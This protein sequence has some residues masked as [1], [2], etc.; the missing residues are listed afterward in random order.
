MY[1]TLP[2]PG[3]L[4]SHPSLQSIL[5][6]FTSK[7][8]PSNSFEA[9][10]FQTDLVPNTF[11]FTD[12][13]TLAV[14]DPS[15]TTIPTPMTT[16]VPHSKKKQTRP[17]TPNLT[18]GPGQLELEKTK[19]LIQTTLT[20]LPPF[21]EDHWK[22]PSQHQ[23]YLLGHQGQTLMSMIQ[24]HHTST[25]VPLNI[26]LLNAKYV[27]HQLSIRPAKPKP[28]F[29]HE[30]KNMKQPQEDMEVVVLRGLQPEV[31]SI[32]QAMQL[33]LDQVH[34]S[35]HMEKIHQQVF[36]P[37]SFIGAIMGPAR[38]HLNKYKETIGMVRVEVQPTSSSSSSSSSTALSSTST[39]GMNFKFFGTSTAV[40]QVVQEVTKKLKQLQDFTVTSIKIPPFYHRAIL[41]DQGHRVKALEAQ[42]HVKIQFPSYQHPQQH[43]SSSANG[44][45]SG[46]RTAAHASSSLDVDTVVVKGP[47]QGVQQA[48]KVL[49]QYHDHEVLH[50][51]TDTFKV[52]SRWIPWL[53]G[54]QGTKLTL[55]RDQLHTRIDVPQRRRK[56]L[57]V[58]D[59]TSKTSVHEVTPPQV[60]HEEED[61]EKEKKGK[62]DKK[63][64]VSQKDK[65]K[66]D[67]ENQKEKDEDSDGVA[68]SIKGT[69][70]QVR[71]TQQVFAE[72]VSAMQRVGFTWVSEIIKVPEQ[73]HRR[74]LGQQ[75][76]H[77]R[78]FLASFQTPSTSSSTSTTTTT[79][80]TEAVASSS[81]APAKNNA[82]SVKSSSSKKNTKKNT[83]PSTPSSSSTS[84]SSE[85]SVK[86]APQSATTK[87][88]SSG[89]TD[90]AAIVKSIYGLDIHPAPS[91][92]PSLPVEVKFLRHPKD[93]VELRATTLELL[94]ELKKKLLSQIQQYQLETI[95]V[96]N[97][98]V[99]YHS[100]L[101]GKNGSITKSIQQEFHVHLDFKPY[102]ITPA[103]HDPAIQVYDVGSRFQSMNA[104]NMTLGSI[105]VSGL[106][107][108]VHL[109]IQ[110]LLSRTPSTQTFQVPLQYKSQVMG[111]QGH[112]L[113]RLRTQFHVTVTLPGKHTGG[114]ST[115]TILTPFTHDDPSSWVASSTSLDPTFDPHLKPNKN[116]GLEGKEEMVEAVETWVLQGT[117]MD[118]TNGLNELQR[119]LDLAQS[120]KGSTSSSSSKKVASSLVK[121]H[122][123]TT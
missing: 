123:T 61:T 99:T 84:L 6:A 81:S 94:Q 30:P 117:E 21:L 28:S 19:H 89:N 111:H 37:H 102:L 113:R 65:K 104:M 118:V 82:P 72:T 36:V 92:E 69:K 96:L 55:L 88:S 114:A 91:S 57:N 106:K 83:T 67:V 51:F 5:T 95:M 68:I 80:T 64:L 35:E 44:P 98:P 52:S 74:L 43:Y 27:N 9:F 90:V 85:A 108:Q 4:A 62:L 46:P 63:K 112:H 54:K 40:H 93:S 71:L 25:D 16:V 17:T 38:V 24:Q 120:K 121:E 3:E 75:G 100:Q 49:Q 77:L 70:E 101:I 11:E 119:L 60:I 13:L 103:Q 58:G 41:G 115:S 42:Y 8:T 53:I 7:S 15:S 73:Y 32:K 33:I 31:T 1:V 109:A 79:A 47:S 122:S 50:S 22:V 10:V 14:F 107:E 48:L 12:T 18:Q 45:A 29:S 34:E 59:P 20:T 26:V 105:C 2:V 23:R 87:P 86:P 116:D 76:Q 97:V 39:D 56:T 110:A 66:E 78:A